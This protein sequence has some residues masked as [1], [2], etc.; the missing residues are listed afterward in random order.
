[1]ARDMET[2]PEDEWQ[3]IELPNHPRADYAAVIESLAGEFPAAWE[4][5]VPAAWDVDEQGR[6][7]ESESAETQGVRAAAWI[8]LS[9][10]HAVVWL[11][12]NAYADAPPDTLT[13][14]AERVLLE[15][16][17]DARRRI[18][19]RPP[20]PGEPIPPGRSEPQQPPASE[21]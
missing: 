9:G 15:W 14:E 4:Y 20:T 7:V 1:M 21:E 5:Q 18:G 16:A 13:A 2:H 10:D 12:P 8:D 11:N 17:S 19:G 6:P 3:K